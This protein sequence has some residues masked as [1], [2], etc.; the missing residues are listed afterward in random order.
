MGVVVAVIPMG[1]WTIQSKFANHTFEHQKISRLL[2]HAGG[3]SRVM[4]AIISFLVR[5]KERQP[6]EHATL[7]HHNFRPIQTP[8]CLLQSPFNGIQF[9]WARSIGFLPAFPRMALY[10]G[11]NQRNAQR[12]HP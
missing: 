2:G 12:N 4:Q 9:K 5:L 8:A 1:E 11:E 10:D 7:M 6:Y 3:N